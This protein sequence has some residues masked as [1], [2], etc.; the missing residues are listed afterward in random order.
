MPHRLETCSYIHHFRQTK[1]LMVSERSSAFLCRPAWVEGL[2]AGGPEASIPDDV[3]A[4]CQS[5]MGALPRPPSL[6]FRVM[7]WQDDDSP[8]A[9]LPAC[10][11]WN[12]N[13]LS[14]LPVKPGDYTALLQ[15][16]QGVLADALSVL[17]QQTQSSHR[18]VRSV[19]QLFN[20]PCCAL[21]SY[22]QGTLGSAALLLILCR[23]L[24]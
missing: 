20:H 9:D 2:L 12:I 21:A 16:L 22:Q 5:M 1:C 4:L 24:H 8:T 14:T 10:C 13:G 11:V 3:R 19:I 17:L 15:R 6:L 18:A 23:R 7:L